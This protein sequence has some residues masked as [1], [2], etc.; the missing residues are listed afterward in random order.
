MY[1]VRIK[2]KEEKKGLSYRLGQ[3]KFFGKSWEKILEKHK[4][5]I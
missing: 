2:R 3:R 4:E 5:N 1:E